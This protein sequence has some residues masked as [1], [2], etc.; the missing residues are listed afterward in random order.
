MAK[1][2]C[3]NVNA[4]F[5]SRRLARWDSTYMIPASSMTENPLSLFNPLFPQSNRSQNP[6]GSH[7]IT[8]NIPETIST[9]NKTSGT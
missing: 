3:L 4:L 1:G 6:V 2:A 8:F 5:M 7:E 9:V